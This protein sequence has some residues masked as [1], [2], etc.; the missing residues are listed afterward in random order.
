M[1]DI[2]SVLPR[3]S[4]EAPVIDNRLVFDK[5][6]EDKVR[7][8]KYQKQMYFFLGFLALADG[9]EM[10]A[11]SILLPVLKNEWGIS[12]DIEGIMGT[13]LFLGIF[14]GSVLSGFISDRF[15]RRKTL[16]LATFVQFV[17]GIVSGITTNLIS[18]LL[19]RGFF[20]LL[21]GFTIPLGPAIVSELTPTEYRG[22][23]IVIINFFFTIGKIYCV[24][25]AKMCLTTIDSGNWRALVM[26]CSIPSLVVSFGTK[27]YLKESPRFLIVTNRIEEGITI[28]NY[29]GQVNNGSTYIPITQEERE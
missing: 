18:F 6:L 10:T 8:G 27:F 26:I 3:T 24:L 15:G 21:I 13:A 22:K 19:I 1:K 4:S 11:L 29:V 14:L 16:I 5:I 2:H 25:V 20:G 17:I 23:G 7:F 9:S 12:D 28:F